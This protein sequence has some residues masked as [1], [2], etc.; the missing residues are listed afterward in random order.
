MIQSAGKQNGFYG[1]CDN[2]PGISVMNHNE[3]MVFNQFFFFTKKISRAL[4]K[5][6]LMH[7]RDALYFKQAI[8]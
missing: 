1:L 5:G 3:E 6:A 7:L 8:S 2:L 4:L